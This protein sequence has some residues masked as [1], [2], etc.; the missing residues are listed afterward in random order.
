MR[1]SLVGPL[2]IAVVGL[3]VIMSL[4][5]ISVEREPGATPPDVPEGKVELRAATGME[6]IQMFDQLSSNATVISTYLS[7]TT[8]SKIRGPIDHTFVGVKMQFYELHCHPITGYV[9]AEYVHMR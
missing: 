5:T 1:D 9:N 6:E 8:C 4:Y 7:G 3:L 2:L